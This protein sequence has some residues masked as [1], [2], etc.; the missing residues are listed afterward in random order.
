MK[1]KS[2]FYLK[3]IS[4]V[5]YCLIIIAGS[6][7]GIPLIMWIVFTCFDFLKIEQL[8]SIAALTGIIILFTKYS[9]SRA[10]KIVGFLFM[11]SPFFIFHM[12]A[13]NYDFFYPTFYIP[14][15]IFIIT[16]LL[17]IIR[18]GILKSKI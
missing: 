2:E 13:S 5:A 18:S 1:N 17:L 10:V 8:V 6:F 9:K 15:S 7:I 4:I 3:I 11:L 16:Q 14:L 12:N